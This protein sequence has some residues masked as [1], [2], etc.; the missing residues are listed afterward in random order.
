MGEGLGLRAAVPI[1]PRPHE[2]RVRAAY[3]LVA[4]PS[5]MTHT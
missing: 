5:S 4:G 3:L 1:S 2:V